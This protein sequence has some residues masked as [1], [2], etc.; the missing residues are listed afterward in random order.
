M[1][2]FTST[3]VK[4]T[5]CI[6]G[7]GYVGEHLVEVFSKGYKVIGYDISAARIE[8]LRTAHPTNYFTTNPEDLRGAR[9][10]CI[11]VP[12]LIKESKV[13]ANYIESACAT[14]MKYAEPG[15]VVVIES[16]VAVGMSRTLLSALHAKGV[17]CGFS[18]ERVDPGRTLPAAEDIPKI[19]SGYDKPSLARITE[20]YS[21]VFRAVVPVSS[22]ETAE[23]CKLSENCFRMINICWINEVSDACLKQ[24]IDPLE[25]INACATKPFGFM[26]FTPGLGVGG[27]CI[28]INPYYLFQNNSLPLLQQ[29]TTTMEQR[30]A[31]KAAAI[32]QS[33]P[34]AK[35]ILVVGVGFKVGQSVLSNSPGLALAKALREL[36]VQVTLYDPLVARVEGFEM[37]DQQ[38][39]STEVLDARFDIIVMVLEQTGVHSETL[40]TLKTAL[41]VYPEFTIATN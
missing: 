40:K 14:V 2:A 29:A 23:M 16:S 26:K 35:R 17:L 37:L 6:V 38:S 30:P 27:H 34:H 39:W 3:P 4:D 13:D 5:I 41:T 18:P 25:M 21:L 1:G 20:I 12:T 33:Y 32:V 28:P 19:I 8:Y 10:F 11:S 24:K 9:V 7:C 36:N 31:Q 15:A 22:M